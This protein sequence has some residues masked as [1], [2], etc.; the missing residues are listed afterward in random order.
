G[1][2]VMSAKHGHHF[3][4]DTPGTDSW[5]HR[6]EGRAERVV[7]AGPDEFAVMGG[8]GGMAVRPLEGLVWDHLMD[9]EIVVAE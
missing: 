5:R 9:A 2:R 6:H 4:V 8:W 1:R 3:K 7:L